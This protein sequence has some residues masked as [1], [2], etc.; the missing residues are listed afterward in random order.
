MTCVLPWGATQEGHL[1]AFTHCSL[2][3]RSVKVAK[4]SDALEGPRK[5]HTRGNLP[6]AELSAVKAPQLLEFQSFLQILR[7]QQGVQEIAEV[8]QTIPLSLNPVSAPC[9]PISSS[10]ENAFYLSAILGL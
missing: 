6:R 10:S 9:L 4:H 2:M 8:Q 7:G 5:G 1:T 3:R